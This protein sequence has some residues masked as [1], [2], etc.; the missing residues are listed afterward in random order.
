MTDKHPEYVRQQL[1]AEAQEA[2]EEAASATANEDEVFAVKDSNSETQIKLPSPSEQLLKLIE[3]HEGAWIGQ[4][5]QEPLLIYGDMGSYKSYFAA[6]LARCRQYLRGHQIISIA[7]RH[8]HQN[9]DECW[10]YLLKL[11]VPGYGAH[12]DYFAVGEPLNAMYSRLAVRTLKDSPLTSIFDEMTGYAQ[13][14]GTQEPASKL[15]RPTGGDPR[16][17]KESPIFIAH[18]NTKAAFGGGQGFSK[19]INTGVIYLELFLTLNNAHYLEE[20]FRQL[21][22]GMASL[23]RIYKLPFLPAAFARNRCFRYSI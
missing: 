9:R 18:K 3:E 7:D 4:L 6:F 17:A 11:G 15:T 16:K 8:F 1:A 12:H 20:I 23:S 19:S 22:M 13:E 2:E 14:E 10:E 21:R 5:M